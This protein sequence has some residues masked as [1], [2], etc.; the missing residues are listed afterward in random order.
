MRILSEKIETVKNYEVSKIIC[1][2]CGKAIWEKGKNK[3]KGTWHSFSRSA[4][5][6][7]GTDTSPFTIEMH[8][9]CWK[10]VQNTFKT[11]GKR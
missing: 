3:Y 7:D 2:Y 6:W 8:D 4:T 11:G 9:E 5:D 10:K 1:D